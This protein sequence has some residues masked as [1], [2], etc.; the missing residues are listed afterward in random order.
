M[1]PSLPPPPIP[2]TPI[3]AV[4]IETPNQDVPV[5][6]ELLAT[7]DIPPQAVSSYE[8]LETGKGV[9]FLLC[10]TPAEQAAARSQAE[11]LLAQWGGQFLSAPPLA[12]RER[13]IQREDWAES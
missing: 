10:D 4:E 9:T 3:H 13:E 6:G 11:A 1:A 2:D 7:L 8:N 12:I 5:L